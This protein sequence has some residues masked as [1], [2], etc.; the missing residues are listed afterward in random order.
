[1]TSSATE[2]EAPA[3]QPSSLAPLG[4]PIFAM[5]WV[6][7]VVSNVGTWM[8]DVGAGWLMTTLSS[9][10][11]LVALVQ[12][13]TTLPVFLFVLPAGVLADLMDRRKILL[14]VNLAMAVIAGTMTALVWYDAMTPELLLLFTFLL[15]SGAAFMAPAWQAIVPSLVPRS[16]LS[17]AI[18]LNSVGINVSRAIGPALAGVLIVWAGI[19]AP[20]LIN[21]L[22]F[23]GILA[24][25]WFWP[26]EQHKRS[27]KEGLLT[28]LVAGLRYAR[29]SAPLKRTIV[30]AI[31]F[32]V[33]ASAYWA[34]LPLVAREILSG[35]SGL[36]GF[37]LGAVGAGAVSGA[38]ILPRLKARFDI[39]T[40]VTLGSLGTALVLVVLAFVPSN[41]AAV[42]AAL[43]AGASWITVLSS[44]HVAA[45]TALPDWVRARGLSIFLTAFFG[46][47]AGGSLIW[48]LV[49]QAV[50]VS[51]ALAIAGAG[52]AAMVLILRAVR[53]EKS[54]GDDQV[55]SMHWPAPPIVPDDAD[56]TGPVM[57][58][59]DYQVADDQADEFKAMMAKLRESRLRDGAYFWQLMRPLEEEGLLRETFL[60]HSWAEHLRQHERVT[61]A[62]RRLQEE[63]KTF[64]IGGTEPRV[65][66]HLPT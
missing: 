9:S 45:Q 17:A 5:L 53:L 58:T 37:L 18:S 61:E 31:G 15:G 11:V 29:H 57:V 63:I 66:H 30:R 44:F 48:G 7:T 33:F 60:L 6:A 25:L 2:N 56:D 14:T 12:T 39:N 41:A 54:E 51:G 27:G 22:S 10:P 3:S 34:M 62:D 8:H 38:V 19:Y 20:F 52:M 40:L 13:A 32:F 49:A 35:G 24:V 64:L 36:Y 26:G 21:A 50:G 47:M 59:I 28:A 42:V 65:R 4:R 43:F 1:M 16:E 46:S 23:L 55:A